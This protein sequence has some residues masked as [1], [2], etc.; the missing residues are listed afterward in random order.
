MGSEH[1][2]V[3]TSKKGDRELLE[4]APRFDTFLALADPTS[5]FCYWTE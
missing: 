4:F 5:S 1:G 2:Q 3:A